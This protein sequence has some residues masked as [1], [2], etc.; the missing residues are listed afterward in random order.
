MLLYT[1]T[2]PNLIYMLY[3][4][5]KVTPDVCTNCYRMDNEDLN[6]KLPYTKFI[7]YLYT[8]INVHL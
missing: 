1:Q 7:V 2:E 5:I 6:V 4:T 3:I 8:H